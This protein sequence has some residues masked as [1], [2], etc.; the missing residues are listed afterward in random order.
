[1]Q[2][3]RFFLQAPGAE[4][5]ILQAVGVGLQKPWTRGPGKSCR[6]EPLN[7]HTRPRPP[8]GLASEV[9]RSPPQDGDGA[10]QHEHRGRLL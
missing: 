9:R 6:Q 2:Q 8:V 5:K 1:M 4:V 3:E 10:H 7:V